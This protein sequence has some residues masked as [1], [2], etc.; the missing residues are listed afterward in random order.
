M[1]KSIILI[2]VFSLLFVSCKNPGDEKTTEKNVEEAAATDE[3]KNDVAENEEKKRYRR[4][5][6]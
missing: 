1:K 6:R 5:K 3:S 4:T 2:I